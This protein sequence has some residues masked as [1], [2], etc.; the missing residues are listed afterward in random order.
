VNEKENEPLTI[1]FL[2][3]GL[4]NLILLGIGLLGNQRKEDEQKAARLLVN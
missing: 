1:R 4:R 2:I 3:P